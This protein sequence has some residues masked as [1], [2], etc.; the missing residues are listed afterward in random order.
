MLVADFLKHLAS[1]HWA[2]TLASPAMSAS[3]HACPICGADTADIGSVRSDFS[4]IDFL[5]RQCDRC[6]LS[7]VANP[8]VDFAA[9]YDAEY[10]RGKGADTFVNYVD[11]MENPHTIRAYEWQGIT[12][13]VQALCGTKDLKWLDFGCGLGGLVRYAKHAGF[14]DVYGFDDGWAAEWAGQ[15]GIPFLR[16]DE[17][18]VHEGTFD[19][20]SAIEVVEHVPD[21]LSLMTQI[22]ALLKPGGVFFL[23]TGNAEP[24]RDALT[25]WSYV[26]PDVHV[27]YFEPRTL[28]EVYKRVGLEPLTGGFLPGYEDIIRYKVLKTLRLSSRNILERLVPWRLAGRVVDRRHK[29]TAQPLARKPAS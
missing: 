14:G 28:A 21:P 18:A 19:V 1:R 12:R 24:H 8:R 22:A 6:G 5:F 7:F 13:S 11:E 27:S 17:L 29:I 2:L 3:Q 20:V 15:N 4:S 16:R 26:H 23:T 9:I 10:Y 25:R